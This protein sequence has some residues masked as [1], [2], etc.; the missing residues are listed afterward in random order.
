[1][2]AGRA[3]LALKSLGDIAVVETVVDVVA[4]AKEVEAT[5]VDPA[6]SSSRTEF[7]SKSEL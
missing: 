5:E 2:R 7:V 4:E 3:E 6:E 1:M